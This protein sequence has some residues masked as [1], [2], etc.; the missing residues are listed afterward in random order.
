M[1]SQKRSFGV[2]YPSTGFEI[3]VFQLP[4]EEDGRGLPQLA[5][6]CAYDSSD[7]TKAPVAAPGLRSRRLKASG[8]T[9]VVL[10]TT[11][12]VLTCSLMEAVDPRQE[13]QPEWIITGFGYHDFDGYGRAAELPGGTPAD[14]FGVGVLPPADQGQARGVRPVPV[15]LGHDAGQLR[16]DG[17]G[18][19]SPARCT[20]RCTTRGRCSPRRTCSR[21]C[22]WHPR[23]A[24]PPRTRPT[25]RWVTDAR[26]ACPTTS[27]GRRAPTGR[28]CG[29]TPTSRAAPRRCAPLWG[30]AGSCTSRMAAPRLTWVARVPGQ[31][32]KF[33]D[34]SA[35][36][37]EVPWSTTFA[38]G[39]VR[40]IALHGLPEERRLPGLLA[41]VSDMEVEVAMA[42]PYAPRGGGTAPRRSGVEGNAVANE[43]RVI[44]Q[45]DA[46]LALRGGSGIQRRHRRGDRG[47]Q[48]EISERTFFRYFATKDDVILAEERRRMEAFCGFLAARRSA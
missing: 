47:T 5:G 48:P 29:G 40:L 6:R 30:R 4:D 14:P 17:H 7:P 43:H 23:S 33:F 10:F 21:A 44:S 25:S 26:W 3:D 46:A 12:A 31:A 8:V 1:Q 24:V 9:T 11:A 28:C 22:S 36:A 16:A 38:G 15:V 34:E 2:V 41:A 32:P 18:S 13:Y 35:S 37:V 45:T 20:R 42:V 39:V 19:R 27:T